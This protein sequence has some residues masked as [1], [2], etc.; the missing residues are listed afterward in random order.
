VL[1]TR[2]SFIGGG[3]MARSIIGG[4]ISQGYSA[5]NLTASD[6]NADILTA[7][8]RDFGVQT[9]VDNVTAVAEAQV[10]V[11]A[12]KPQVM[13]A[14]CLG[15][16]PQLPAQCLV[17][18]IAAGVSCGSLKQW[19]GAQ[20]HIVRAMPNTPAL[21]LAGASGLYAAEGVTTE[22]K[23][24]AEQL[25]NAVGTV[26]WVAEENLIDAVTAV[27]GSGPAYF[28][29]LLEAMVDAA[30]QQGLDRNT[31]RQ[32]AVQTALGAARLAQSDSDLELAELRRR[33]TS[34]GGTTERA[35]AA[36]EQHQFRQTVGIAMQACANRARQMADELGR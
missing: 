2:I 30:E 3:N 28:F 24:L 10:V 27:S 6:P 15:L 13:K 17:I 29:L 1:N 14:V 32:L 31:A 26:A 20:R 4:L 22:E 9:T 7:L 12:V 11:L 18:S 23:A 33:V 5:E 19:L 35:I 21:V 34:P 36:F 8:T 25:L 16:A